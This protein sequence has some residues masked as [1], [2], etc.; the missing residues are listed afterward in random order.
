M[1]TDGWQRQFPDHFLRHR[2][3]NQWAGPCPFCADHGHD[4]FVI[5]PDDDNY[6]CSACEAKGK[7]SAYLEQFGIV[8]TEARPETRPPRQQRDEITYEPFGWGVAEYFASSL[9][10]AVAEWVEQQYSIDRATQQALRFGWGICERQRF[11]TTNPR[12]LIPIPTDDGLAVKGFKAR[13]GPSSA[14]IPYHPK[15]HKGK[16]YQPDAQGLVAPDKWIQ[17]AGTDATLYGEI[18]PD[19]P[20]IHVGEGELKRGVFTCYGYAATT[21]TTGAATFKDE[22]AIR[23]R[24]ASCVY[25]VYDADDAGAKGAAKA[26]AVLRE[27]AP[28]L[29]VYLVAWPDDVPRGYDVNDYVREAVDKHAALATLL[30]KARGETT[31]ALQAVLRDRPAT[32]RGIE[33]LPHVAKP[34]A[35]HASIQAVREG[36][37]YA[38]VQYLGAMDANKHDPYALLIAP[39]PGSGKTTQIIGALEH[40]DLRAMYAAPRRDMWWTIQQASED[41]A[42]SFGGEVE[43]RASEWLNLRAR[44]P[45]DEYGP[46]NCVYPEWAHKA[47]AKRRHVF[48]LLCQ[49]VC[50]KWGACGYSR[51]FQQAQE[52]SLVFGRHQHAVHTKMAGAYD[53][54]VIDEDSRDAFFEVVSLEPKEM[55]INPGSPAEAHTLVRILQF[56]TATTVG[57]Q[58]GPA[59]IPLLD[60]EC[61]NQTSPDTHS[62][63]ELCALIDDIHPALFGEPEIDTAWQIDAVEQKWF[64]DFWKVLRHEL[65]LWSQGAVRWNSRLCLNGGKLHITLV[66]KLS[67]GTTPI[68]IADGTGNADLYAELLGRRVETYRPVIEQRAEVWQVTDRQNGKTS[69]L[70]QS[71]QAWQELAS[72]VQALVK[73]EPNSLVVTFKD[74]LGRLTGLPETVKLAHFGALVGSNEYKDCRQVIL[75]GTPMPPIHTLEQHAQ[76]LFWRDP[77]LIDGRWVTRLR[78]YDVE[79]DEHGLVQAYAVSEFADTRANLLLEQVREAQMYQSFE[80][81]R[82]LLSK[83]GEKRVVLLSNI[84]LPGVRVQRLLKVTDLIGPRRTDK[85]EEMEAYLLAMDQEHGEVVFGQIEAHFLDLGWGKNTIAKYRDQA[86]SVLGWDTV[87]R[88]VGRG[89]PPKVC[90]PGICLLKETV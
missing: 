4:R 44:S 90:G 29:T 32:R 28:D 46:A 18:R 50:G 9:P 3:K 61:R 57:R 65:M 75:A 78:P 62:L 48:S 20:L 39:P 55:V 79:P 24:V 21:S 88:S 71:G 87:T 40:L 54:L 15:Y 59:L 36:M 12:L 45:D 5:W 82:T 70:D 84:P 49:G 19:E 38:I 35:D 31:Q 72:T 42:A 81:I 51:Q 67:V 64:P 73:D 60:A 77:N 26:Y 14:R 69:L 74:V 22:W 25:L 53:V 52:T 33:Y 1:S 2:A 80:R 41:A 13:L 89:R 16:R 11:D 6:W 56:V 47:K 86:I 83:D 27:H 34:S 10:D 23:M 68:I 8:I 7:L 37:L 17:S 85:Q 30:S 43:S 66:H 76:A 63:A 58:F